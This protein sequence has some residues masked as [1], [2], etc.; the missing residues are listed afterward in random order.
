MGDP[1]NG[2]LLLSLAKEGNSD[3]GHH[4]D[5]P[6]DRM[7]STISQ[8]QKDKGCVIPAHAGYLARPRA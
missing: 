7:L 5:G 2:L 3:P 8:P 1:C 4:M 6:E